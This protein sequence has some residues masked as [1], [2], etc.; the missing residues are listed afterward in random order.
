MRLF[1][2]TTFDV[3]KNY[4]N[5]QGNA[6]LKLMWLIATFYF[7]TIKAYHALGFFS[8][9]AVAGEEEADGDAW[10]ALGLWVLPGEGTLEEVGAAHA[11]WSC[12]G[13]RPA[14]GWRADGTASIAVRL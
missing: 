8:N 13:D 5:K 6:G 4:T 9:Q 2:E 14:W 12:L 11:I 10:M 1:S 3:N 7:S